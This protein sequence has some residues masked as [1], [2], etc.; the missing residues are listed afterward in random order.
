MLPQ[1]CVDWTC[2]GWVGPGRDPARHCLDSLPNSISPSSLPGGQRSFTAHPNSGIVPS[3][4]GLAEFTQMTGVLWTSKKDITPTAV[5]PM[6]SSHSP[7]CRGSWRGSH[8]SS[9]VLQATGACKSREPEAQLAGTVPVPAALCVWMD[10]QV[11][12]SPKCTTET[13]GHMRNYRGVLSRG[14]RGGLVQLQ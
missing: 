6:S 5:T 7:G 2:V 1:A 10:F 11:L 9:P 8:S 14:C 4:Q 13:R 3:N 12:G